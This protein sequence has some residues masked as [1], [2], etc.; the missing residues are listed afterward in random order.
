MTRRHGETATRRRGENREVISASFLPRVF[1]S[2]R[3]CEGQGTAEILLMLPLFVILAGGALCIGYMCWQGLK[4]QQAAN[5]AARM[6]GQQ[7]VG[8][9][10]T[11]TNINVENGLTGTGDRAPT[12]EEAQR[13]VTDINALN[14]NRAG[15]PPGGVYGD[16]YKAVRNMFGV[17]E[18]RR[19]VV[20]PPH[21]GANT[22]A[23]KVVRVLKPPKI[24][25]LQLKPVL[26]E[27]YAYGGEDTR[28]Y[29]L[30]RWGGTGVDPTTPF[31][32]TAIPRGSEP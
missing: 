6:Q 23:V 24:L 8:G 9:G 21:R 12:R 4:V 26:L 14:G 10:T 1:A 19:L 5:L 3:R 27:A 30:P 2:P 25:D 22:D 28:M 16:F 15:T 17:K 18:G 32:K 20:P 11:A 29:G 7:R 31:Y 13:M